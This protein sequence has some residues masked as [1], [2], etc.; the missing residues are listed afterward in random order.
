MVQLSIIKFCQNLKKK[1]DS[2][3]NCIIFV[4]N[5]GA[6]STPVFIGTT[7]LKNSSYFVNSERAN[8]W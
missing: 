5:W 4:K 3:K 8:F 7:L 6:E 1:R 2:W